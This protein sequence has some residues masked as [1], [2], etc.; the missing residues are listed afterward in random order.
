MDPMEHPGN[1]EGAARLSSA[2]IPQPESGA[3]LDLSDDV[4]RLQLEEARE[5]A[6]VFERIRTT[7]IP[8]AALGGLSMIAV[9]LAAADGPAWL[10]AMLGAAAFGGVYGWNEILERAWIRKC[11]QLG[12]SKK[13][14]SLLRARVPPVAF[15][16]NEAKVERLARAL[17]TSMESV[18]SVNSV[19]SVDSGEG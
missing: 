2:A 15:E 16:T 12:L 4:S 5:L 10:W 9:A 13:A 1:T 19:E 17:M 6:R 8:G 18:K 7:W 3:K 14:A 11:A